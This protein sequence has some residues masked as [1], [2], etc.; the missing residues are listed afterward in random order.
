M[1]HVGPKNSKAARSVVS[2]LLQPVTMFASASVV[3]ALAITSLWPLS[4]ALAQLQCTPTGKDQT[5]SNSIPITGVQAGIDD[6]ATVTITNN[7]STIEATGSTTPAGP[8]VGGIRAVGD[9][10]VTNNDLTGAI[11]ATGAGGA[12]IIATNGTVTVTKNLGSISGTAFGIRA[13][14]V[15][16][17]GNFDVIEARAADGQAIHAETGHNIINNFANGRI[18]GGI[19]GT[20]G[21]AGIVVLPTA[22]LELTNEG[23]ISG[24]TVGVQGSGTV[25][26]SGKISGLESVNFSGVDVTNKLTL[27][28]GSE[29]IG[30]AQ[31]SV[32]ATNN[33]FLQ[34]H[35]TASNR[36]INF[37]S[38][39]VQ[40]DAT[41]WVWNTDVTIDP[42][43][44]SLGTTVSSGTFVV[45]GR[46]GAPAGEP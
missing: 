44:G 11:Q 37:N 4:E 16:I 40:A 35:G 26:N 27:Q 6:G 29:L 38:L 10:T 32:G 17:G 5:C 30:V 23:T 7:T 15:N 1:K 12:G 33:L 36:F 42:T 46:S 13:D 34:G 25:T 28:T 18:T 39:D 21:G 22:T 2:A 31:G 19:D 20:L 45:G 43:A 14:T 24:T 8:N 41:G 9:V 3:G